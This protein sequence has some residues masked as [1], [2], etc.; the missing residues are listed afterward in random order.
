MSNHIHLIQRVMSLSKAILLETSRYLQLQ[1][2]FKRLK[3][4][5]RKIEELDIMTI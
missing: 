3:K 2:L 1:R 4:M 5:K